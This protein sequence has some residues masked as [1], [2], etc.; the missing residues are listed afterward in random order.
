MKKVNEALKGLEGAEFE[1]YDNEKCEGIPLTKTLISDS[2]GMT[3]I[4]TI[5]DIPFDQEEFTVYLKEVKAPEGYAVTDEI[6]EY[7]FTRAKYEELKAKGDESGELHIF[8]APDGIVNKEGW[9]IRVQAK[10]VKEDLTLLQELN[11]MY[12]LTLNVSK[13]HTEHLFLKR[14]E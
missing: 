12:I 7:T 11:L 8:G 2:T 3:N 5:K 14:M 4:E 6:F 10:K 1:V 9:K 13:N